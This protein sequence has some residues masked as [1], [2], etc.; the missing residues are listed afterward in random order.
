MGR[1]ATISLRVHPD[2]IGP[3][4]TQ[5]ILNHFAMSP[6]SEKVCLVL[7]AKGLAW[8]EHTRGFGHGQPGT[9]SSSEALAIAAAATSHAPTSCDPDG[10]HAAG[11]M[12]CVTP[13]DY[14]QDPVT[15]RLVGLG[16]DEVVLERSDARAGKLHVHFPRVGYRIEAVQAPG[17]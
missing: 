5:L 13:N 16:R 17:G 11:A 7:G 8:F 14:A 15:G 3:N 2:A 10:G 4:M 12:V 6:F 9:I 1:H